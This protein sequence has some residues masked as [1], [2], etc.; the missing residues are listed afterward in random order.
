RRPPVCGRNGPSQT[1]ASCLRARASTCAGLLC[2]YPNREGGQYQWP[3]LVFRTCPEIKRAPSMC[4]PGIPGHMAACASSPVDVGVVLAQPV[5]QFRLELVLRILG[6]RE[7][8]HVG[9]RVALEQGRDVAVRALERH[10]ADDP[11]LVLVVDGID[12]RGLLPDAK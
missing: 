6:A 3:D 4:F 10:L 8:H 5:E 1:S 12:A 9:G 2:F 11:L 7:P